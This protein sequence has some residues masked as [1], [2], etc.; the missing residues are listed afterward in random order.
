MVTYDSEAIYVN[1]GLTGLS[2]REALRLRA[3][4]IEA[5]QD[6]LL[7]TAL[8]A[9]SKGA[10]EY[11]LNTGQSVI[12]LKRRTP[13]QLQKAWQDFEV[14]RQQIV[15]QLNGRMVRLVDGKNF[16]GNRYGI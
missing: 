11:Q 12:K 9:A 5:I 8:D 10:D 1:S 3:I 14:I 4:R 13:E 15:N 16:I 7:T 6:A 2:R